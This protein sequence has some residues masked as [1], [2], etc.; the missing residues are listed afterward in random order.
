[1]RET[2]HGNGVSRGGNLRNLLLGRLNEFPAKGLPKNTLV[3]KDA[4]PHESCAFQK[5]HR[6][7]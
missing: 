4:D 6:Q 5:A 7:G 1:M 3:I 2:A